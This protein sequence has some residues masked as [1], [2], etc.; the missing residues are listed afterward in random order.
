[1]PLPKHMWAMVLPAPGGALALTELPVPT[2]RAHEI[3]IRVLACGVCRTDL[4]IVD[5]DL[6]PLR[7]GIVPG[8]EIVGRVVATGNRYS[9]FHVGDRIGIPWLGQTCSHCNFCLDQQENLCDAPVFTGYTC[10][11]GFAQYAVAD[12]RFC[13]RLPQVYEHANAAPLLC[14]GLIGYRAYR[15]CGNGKARRIG[16]YGFGAAAHIL[17]Q[18]AVAQG[19]SVYAFLREGDSQGQEFAIQLGAV[20]A[21]ASNTLPDEKLDA[22]IIFAPVG[23][24]IPA[25]LRSIRKG[26]TVVCAGIHMSKIPAFDYSLLWGERILRSVANLTRNDGLEFFSLIERKPVKTTVHTFQLAH[27]NEAISAVRS[28]TLNGAAVLLP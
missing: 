8:H 11:G 20:W 1:M 18:I 22:A 9:P 17:C 15:L 27:A 5:G 12:E 26:G 23:N 24:L 16:L 21:G 19:E 25:A 6:P 3:L 13:F 4:H 10:H 28:G 7:S 2:P 14:A